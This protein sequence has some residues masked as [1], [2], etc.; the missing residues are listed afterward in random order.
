MKPFVLLFQV[1][2][3]RMSCDLLLRQVRQPARNV[4]KLKKVALFFLRIFKNDGDVK[5]QVDDTRGISC[6]QKVGAPL[7]ARLA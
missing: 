1:F 5:G 2:T 3:F 4:G 6:K 7:F